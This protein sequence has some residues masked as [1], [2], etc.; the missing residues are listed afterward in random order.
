MFQVKLFV[1]KVGKRETAKAEEGSEDSAF[2]VQDGDVHKRMIVSLSLA[3]TSPESIT[4]SISTL[5]WTSL[6][7]LLIAA[8]IS[9]SKYFAMVCALSVSSGDFIPAHLR[10]LPAVSGLQKG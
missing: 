8:L 3:L 4:L 2:G 6:L 9:S 5:F 10:H 1:S 7:S